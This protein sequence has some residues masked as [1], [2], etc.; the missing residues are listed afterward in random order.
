MRECVVLSPSFFVFRALA[1]LNENH[2][3]LLS[4]IFLSMPKPARVQVTGTPLM[5]AV[6][7]YRVPSE[8]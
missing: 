8:Q 2:P 5:A 7:A 1:S 3:T 4:L 6:M